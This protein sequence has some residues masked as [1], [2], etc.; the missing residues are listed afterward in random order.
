MTISTSTK[1]T[2]E[3]VTRSDLR[4][5]F[6]YPPGRL[7]RLQKARA[8]RVPTEFFF[9][10]VEMEKAGFHIEHREIELKAWQP[11]ALP[12]LDAWICR[13]FRDADE[14]TGRGIRAAR[15]LSRSFS[16]PDWPFGLSCARRRSQSY[17]FEA[18][19][20][21]LLLRQD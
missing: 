13:V 19:F 5:L 1:P 7:S 18:A 8:G 4:V 9:G 20:R 15:S 2:K 16:L 21:G 14:L 6:L 10:G 12:S 11:L 3:A 17:R